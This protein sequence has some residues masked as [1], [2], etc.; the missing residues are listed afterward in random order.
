MFRHFALE[1]DMF[2]NYLHRSNVLYLGMGKSS[3]TVLKPLVTTPKRTVRSILSASSRYHFQ[4]IIYFLRLLN[5]VQIYTYMSNNY[6]FKALNRPN[7]LT[8]FY[9]IVFSTPLASQKLY[10]WMYRLIVHCK[11]CRFLVPLKPMLRIGYQT[12]SGK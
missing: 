6:V 7:I 5:F 1:H 3:L 8:D 9:T 4:A 10:L 11:I 2:H 12:W